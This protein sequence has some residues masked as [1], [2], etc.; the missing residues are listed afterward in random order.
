[1]E[2]AIVPIAQLQLWPAVLHSPGK[3]FFWLCK[4]KSL[5][6]MFPS[7]THIDA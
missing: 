6:G 5:R 7:L 3:N 1:M 2:F 4:M